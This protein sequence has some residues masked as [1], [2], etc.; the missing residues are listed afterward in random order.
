MAVVQ[1]RKF[2]I[3]KQWDQQA[4]IDTQAVCDLAKNPTTISNTFISL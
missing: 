2:N 4:S 1:N 3:L